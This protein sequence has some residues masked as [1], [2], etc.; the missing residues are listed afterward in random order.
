MSVSR[1]AKL[2]PTCP[3]TYHSAAERPGHT[4]PSRTGRRIPIDNRPFL[5]LDLVRW[6]V[7]L[8]PAIARESET[9]NPAVDE[10]LQLMQLVNLI[11][12]QSEKRATLSSMGGLLDA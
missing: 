4:R 10:L 1:S 6:S 11:V 2:A 3:P 7:M 9:R 8:S 5:A 12:L